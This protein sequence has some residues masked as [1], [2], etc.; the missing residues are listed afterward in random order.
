MSI[1]RHGFAGLKG[2]ANISTTWQVVADGSLK[3]TASGGVKVGVVGKWY[4]T[5]LCEPID[6]VEV[7]VVWKPPP[8]KPGH[9]PPKP[10]PPGRPLDDPDNGLVGGAVGLQ[11]MVPEGAVL[12]AWHV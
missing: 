6:G 3:V 5:D 11:F 2:P 7:P 1:K 4:G 10:L 8:S 9:L 12:Y